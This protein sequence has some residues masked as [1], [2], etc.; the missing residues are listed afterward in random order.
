MATIQQDGSSSVVANGKLGR[1]RAAP[2]GQAQLQVW[3]VSNPN[4]Q[5]VAQV[6]VKDWQK[7]GPDM[8]KAYADGVPF[9]PAQVVE[10]A[11]E[12]MTGEQAALARRDQLERGRDALLVTPE[13]ERHLAVE[14]Y[15]HAGLFQGAVDAVSKE[16]WPVF[17][18]EVFASLYGVR[19]HQETTHAADEWMLELLQQAEQTDEWA[20]LERVCARNPWAAGLGAA[21]VL[22]ALAAANESTLKGLPDQDPVR[23][24]QEAA[25]LEE[26][27]E[28]AGVALEAISSV[29]ANQAERVAAALAL[30]ATG[31][32]LRR[33]IRKAAGDAVET[34]EGTELALAGLGAGGA[35]GVLSR[36]AAP[37]KA[38]RDALEKNDRLRRIATIAGRM[39]ARAHGKQRTKTIYV[40]E[41]VVDVTVGGE[42]AR[43]LPSELMLLAEPATEALLQRKLLESNALEYRLEG[44]EQADR[45]P[46]VLLVDGSGSMQGPRHEWAMGIALALVEVCAMQRR[47]FA[48]VHFDQAVQRRWEVPKPGQVGLQELIDAVCYFSGGGTRFQAPLAVARNI[49]ERGE[50]SKSDVVLV[51]DGQ[52]ESGG[53]GSWHGEVKALNK[54]GAQVYGVSVECR[55]NAA[56]REVLAGE[57]HVDKLEQDGQLD[58]V[59]GI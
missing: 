57:A 5:V 51:T 56:D 32:R 27:K 13:F 44:K 30:P 42:L 31:E 18:R 29:G 19:E 1:W 55:F 54:A 46:I 14:E 36:V 28:G 40:P 7:H 24:E 38:I 47:P 12:T 10:V 34:I 6:P 21:K 15:D 59:F 58:L 37:K 26:L 50:F 22:K 43:L 11:G 20:T 53:R 49:I 8:L 41:Q 35:P 48:L 33:A 16:Q 39:R 52:D 2:S 17:A 23:Q 45:G 3:T 9:A 25:E 4:G